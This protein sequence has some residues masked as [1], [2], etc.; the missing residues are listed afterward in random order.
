[1]NASPNIKVLSI[2]TGLREFPSQ[3]PLLGSNHHSPG[4]VWK[5]KGT[6]TIISGVIPSTNNA[7]ARN[8]QD[9]C[10][11]RNT[12]TPLSVMESVYRILAAAWIGPSLNEACHSLLM[13]GRYSENHM[14][15]QRR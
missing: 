14:E 1:M 5:T 3:N 9:H 10:V 12:E 15:W 6:T 2:D 7:G 13:H 11:F 4:R 8:W